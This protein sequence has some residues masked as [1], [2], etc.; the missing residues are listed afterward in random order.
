MHSRVSSQGEGFW[1]GYWPERIACLAAFLG[2]L[3]AELT[4][5]D[6]RSRQNAASDFKTLYASAWCFAHRIDAYSFKEIARV[7]DFSH[8]VQPYSWY[9]H[10]PVYPPFTLAFLAPFTLAPMVPATYLWI[11]LSALAIASAIALLARAGGE[12]LEL[13]RPWRIALIVLAAVSPLVSAGLELGNVSVL[14][15]ALCI[16]AAIIPAKF[17]L[18][19]PAAGL[20]T[21]LFL[22]PHIAVWVF[23]ALA[24]LQTGRKI[25]IRTCGLC[26]GVAIA[27]GLWMATQHM[28]FTQIESYRRVLASELSS[29]SM[30]IGSHQLLEVIVQITSL[31]S[32]LGYWLPYGLAPKLL[33]S[34][35]LLIMAT[36]LAWSTWRLRSAQGESRFCIIGGWC[37]FGMTATYHR[38]HD[39]IVLLL[40]LAV[41][42][43]RLHRSF[44]DI[45]GWSLFILLAATSVGPSIQTLGWLTGPHGL[46][47]YWQFL[48]IRQAALANFLLAILLLAMIL[49]VAKKRGPADENPCTTSSDS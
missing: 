25:A 20:T 37:A 29:G 44:R 45:W 21:A 33:G 3:G 11:L 42:M 9:A 10:A 15:S 14:V 5:F 41:V 26:A 31:E 16:F 36:A 49:N 6:L 18:W 27:M 34:A 4:G 46:D 19:L 23:I 24:F 13:G 30:A 35:V 48:L 7:F 47:G 12:T 32:L 8:V 2:L 40:L 1:S 38:A 28:L 22:K 39:G 17:N 43:S